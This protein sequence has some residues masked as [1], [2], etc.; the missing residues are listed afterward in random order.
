MKNYLVLLLLCLGFS[1]YAQIGGMG[2][3]NRSFQDQRFRQMTQ[4][5][6]NVKPNYEIEKYLGIVIYEI[7]KAAKKSSIKLNSDT[8]KQF[9]SILT[10]YNKT[11]RDFRRINSFTLRST[12]EM[13]EN[14]QTE[15]QK[16]RDFSG[17]E[18]IQ[19]KMAKDLKPINETLTAEDRKLD[20]TL[21]S[22]L[23]EKQYDKW[24]KYNR[25]LNKYFPKDK[26]EE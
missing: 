2:M 16:T 7:E 5:P 10:M 23:S 11:I 13:V 26:K 25:K 9:Q 24:I 15:A 1:S 6:N 14:F 12:K 20:Q 22:L 19:K 18:A 4:T 8:G 21:K 17:Y 3:R